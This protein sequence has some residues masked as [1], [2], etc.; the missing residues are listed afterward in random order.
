MMAAVYD[1]G[2]R[3]PKAASSGDFWI[4][5]FEAS[6]DEAK[7]GSDHLTDTPGLRFEGLWLYFSARGTNIVHL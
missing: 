2:V 5:S 7:A 1:P 4:P 6:S 3:V